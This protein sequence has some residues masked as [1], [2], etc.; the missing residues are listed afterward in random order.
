[1]QAEPKGP[2][3]HLI[4]TYFDLSGSK[5]YELND[6]VWTN[7]GHFEGLTERY[8]IILTYAIL[9]GVYLRIRFQSVDL[10]VRELRM[11]YLTARFLLKV[12]D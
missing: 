8:G 9:T 2:E 6:K 12:A 3:K 7:K 10:G 1:M 4:R 5:L 11:T